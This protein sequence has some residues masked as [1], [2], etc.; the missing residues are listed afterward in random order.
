[1]YTID[2]ERWNCI[3]AHSFLSS[4]SSILSSPSLSHTH[5]YLLNFRNAKTA[6]EENDLIDLLLGDVGI[7]QCVLD[8]ARNTCC[9]SQ[10]DAQCE[11]ST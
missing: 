5:T 11:A 10:K 7:A 9:C 4:H 6:A 8:R 2:V 1:M 3:L